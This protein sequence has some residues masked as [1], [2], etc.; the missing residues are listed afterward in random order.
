MGWSCRRAPAISTI[1][2]SE[3][4]VARGTLNTVGQW[5]TASIQDTSTATYGLGSM[6]VSRTDKYMNAPMNFSENFSEYFG[7]AVPT[8]SNVPVTIADWTRPAGNKTGTRYGTVGR[9][10]RVNVARA[11]AAQ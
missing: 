11:V 2:S 10:H 9:T 1:D 8:G 5:W 6:R 4:H 7:P 3:E